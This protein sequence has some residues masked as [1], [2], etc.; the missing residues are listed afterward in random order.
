MSLSI[1]VVSSSRDVRDFLSVPHR[2]YHNTPQWVPEFRSDLR[3]VIRRRHP[4]FDHAT[5]EFF[6]VR[7]G[8]TPVV[9][10]AVVI[11]DVYNRAHGLACV[12]FYY[13]D[14][15]KDSA[16]VRLFF[17]TAEDW[18]RARG[19]NEIR[20]PMMFGGTSGS[21]VL[22]DGFERRAAMTMMRY[23]H[24]YYAHFLEDIGFTPLVDLYSAEFPPGE[25]QLPDRISR[26]AEIAAKRS[27]I[28]VQGFRNKRALRAA[29]PDIQALYNHTLADHI[30]DYP[31]SQAE[32]DVVANELLTVADPRLIKVLRCED[33]I[34]GF[35]FAFPDVSET[36]RKNRGRL[37][38]VAIVRLLLSFRRAP[39]V[40]FNGMGILPEYQ[41]RGG[42]ALLYSELAKTVRSR[43]FTSAEIVQVAGE[44]TL[45]LRDLK[46][47]GANITKTHR[48]YKKDYSV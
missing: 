16:A 5:A 18:A 2:I 1:D 44:T 48:I 3:Q 46:N 32:L 9:R 36:L 34:V 20:G 22:V 26:V 43:G 40:L 45:M 6:V 30:E 28:L 31:L 8:I 17:S 33:N 35:L 23:N 24:P 41:R 4:I 10:G 14:A 13:F 38:P 37:T 39:R 47:L 7:R 29:V 11:N 12:S 25:L 27:R 15:A 21:G 42:N 19:M